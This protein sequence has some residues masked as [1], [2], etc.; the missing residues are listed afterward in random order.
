MFYL[1]EIEGNNPTL[2]GPWFT[3]LERDAKAMQIR[4]I[5]AES[6]LLIWA[7]LSNVDS[8]DNFLQ[9]RQ[10]AILL[11]RASNLKIGAYND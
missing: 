3:E 2:L 5:Q 11:Q 6:G 8:I 10:S 9:S 7:N 4:A 1:I